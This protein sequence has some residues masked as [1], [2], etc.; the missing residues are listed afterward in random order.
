MRKPF[1]FPVG[2][3]L[4]AL[5]M[6]ACIGAGQ[7]RPGS[8]S[9]EDM[10][11]A[12]VSLQPES[13]PLGPDGGHAVLHAFATTNGRPVKAL[14][15]VVSRSS[16]GLTIPDSLVKTDADGSARIEVNAVADGRICIAKAS[17]PRAPACASEL[18]TSTGTSAFITVARPSISLFAPTGYKWT[19]SS[20][21]TMTI[22]GTSFSAEVAV[23]VAGNL[24]VVKKASR[25]V[26]EVE[27]SDPA[28]IGDPALTKVTVINL[29]SSYQDVRSGVSFTL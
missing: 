28:T 15:L 14:G 6:P 23:L 5:L 10:K 27:F 24:A 11:A 4:S 7:P 25:S 12:E 22:I 19:G 18:G 1:S 2:A 8:V 21:H 13:I 9:P 17:A 20:K 26:I 29:P 3:L 16:S